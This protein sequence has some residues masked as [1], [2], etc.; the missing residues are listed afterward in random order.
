MS[1]FDCL[2]AHRRSVRAYDSSETLIPGEI[3][4]IVRAAQEAPSWKNQQTSR[5]HVA[6]SPEARE[7]VLACLPERNRHN[8]QHASA[9]VVTSFV[10]GNVGF[11]RDGQPINELGDGWGI[12]DLGLH[13]ALF[14]LKATDLGLDSLVM[15]IRDAEALQAALQ[16]PANEKVVAVI[17]LGRRAIDPIRPDRKPLPEILTIK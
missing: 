14:L 17:A 15:G 3:E 2:I 10:T 5:Y 1:D 11:D 8:A 16:I 4:E 13:N 12:Y 7:A 6:L 9:L